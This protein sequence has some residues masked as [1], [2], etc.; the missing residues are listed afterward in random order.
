MKPLKWLW[1]HSKWDLI[2]VTSFTLATLVT[3]LAI[4]P[5]ETWYATGIIVPVWYGLH[6]LR[7]GVLYKK[8][9]K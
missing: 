8:N 3:L 4:D 1:K 5:V 9:N 7:W 2:G 6:I